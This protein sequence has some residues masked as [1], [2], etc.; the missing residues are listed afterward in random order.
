MSDRVWRIP[1]SDTYTNANN[2]FNNSY[3]HPNEYVYLDAN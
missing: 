1:M 2:K 3:T